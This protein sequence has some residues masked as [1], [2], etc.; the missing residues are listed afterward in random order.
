MQS[1]ISWNH[2]S[3]MYVGTSYW[4]RLSPEIK[5]AW[6]IYYKQKDRSGVCYSLREFLYWYIF[7]PKRKKLI[8]PNVA[9]FDHAKPYSWDN[10]ELQEQVENVRERN[11]RCGNPGK[12]HRSVVAFDLVSGKKIK[13]FP[14]K[15]AAA[16][17]FGVSEKTV[18][19]HCQKRTK[20]FFKFGPKFG[21]DR[22]F[23]FTWK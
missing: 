1:K 6:S 12:T 18:Y 19:N 22:K 14:T 21:L 15:K 23:T 13:E 17:Y 9:R 3:K 10:I 11:S 8:L 2:K 20:Q 16:R 4:N 5:R 7:H